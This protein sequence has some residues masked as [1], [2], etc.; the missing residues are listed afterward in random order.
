MNPQ[1]I[2]ES[3]YRQAMAQLQSVTDA[4]FSLVAELEA[5]RARIKE[6]ETP[7]T[8]DPKSDS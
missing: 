6:L 4:V 1:S 3:K 7:L 5:A 2:L 8:P